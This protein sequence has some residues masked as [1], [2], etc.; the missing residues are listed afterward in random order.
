MALCSLYIEG[1]IN[2]STIISISLAQG[3]SAS[4][5]RWKSIP[6]L[7]TLNKNS[8]SNHKNFC[9]FHC[10]PRIILGTLVILTLNPGNMPTGLNYLSYPC[11]TDEQKGFTVSIA[12]PHSH[13]ASE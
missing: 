2:F 1:I 7:L 9:N 10:L 13:S 3:Y 8:S 4:K 11:F 5:W 6:S 12:L